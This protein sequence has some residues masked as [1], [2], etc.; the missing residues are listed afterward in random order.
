MKTGYYAYNF[1]LGRQHIYRF[2]I[3]LKGGGGEIREILVN[4]KVTR[5]L[6]PSLKEKYKHGGTKLI[7]HAAK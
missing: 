5:S 4:N 7:L 1:I 2:S 6:L 3:H